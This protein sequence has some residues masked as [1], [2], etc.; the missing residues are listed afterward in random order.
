MR[1]I[2]AWLVSQLNENERIAAFYCDGFVGICDFTSL[3]M[4]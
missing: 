2:F 3:R 1:Q 4:D